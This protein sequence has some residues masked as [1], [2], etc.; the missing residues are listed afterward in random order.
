MSRHTFKDHDAERTR[1]LLR[2]GFDDNLAG[3]AIADAG[4]RIIACN[5]E[6]VRITGCDSAPAF[7]H[8]L[9]PQPGAFAGLL[10][11]LDEANHTSGTLMVQD[12][13][14]FVRRDDSP[15]QVIARI[16]ASV[17]DAGSIAETRVYLVDITDRFREEQELRVV[18]DRLQLADVAAQDVL[19]DWN[20]PAARVEW[21]SATARRFRYMSEE[22]RTGIDWHAE[23]VHPV[24]RERILRGLQRAMSGTDSTWTNEYRL[25]RGDGS[26]AAVLDRAHIV[27]N[28]RGEPVRVV[29]SIVDIT[30]LK[31]SEDAHRFLARAGAALEEVLDVNATAASLAHIGI[32]EYA[33]LCL[34]DLLQ[35]DGSLHRVAVAHAQPALEPALSL[36]ATVP[37]R[38]D[39]NSASMHAV[40][41]GE[42]ECE[43]G[44]EVGQNAIMKR[45]GLTP[46]ADARAYIVVPLEAR[47]RIMGAVTFGFSSPRRFFDPL[48]IQTVK[49]LAGCAAL[50][51]GNAHLYESAQRAIRSRNEVLGIV[52]HDLRSPLHTIVATLS[53]LDDSMPERRADIR[54][55]F[56]ILQRTTGQINHLIQDL[57]DVSRMES[58]HFTVDPRESSAAAIITEACETLRPLAAE[59]DIVISTDIRGDL[60]AVA[61]DPPEVVRVIG[62]LIGNAIKFSPAGAAIVVR[63]R[64]VHGEVRISVHDE[65]PG[66]PADQ[67]P[68]VFEHFW[69]GREKDRRGSGLGLAIARGIVEAHGGRIWVDSALDDG[70][71]FTFSLPV[72]GVSGNGRR[73]AASTPDV[74]RPDRPSADDPQADFPQAR[75]R[76]G[77]KAAPPYPDRGPRWPPRRRHGPTRG[78]G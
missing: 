73:A 67:I 13:I 58:M 15:M 24:D 78:V 44:M 25:L 23:R 61:A 43:S 63:A 18:A 50:A 70:S 16:S 5:R 21:G 45:L 65:G 36:N 74:D 77:R 10:A 54:R 64:A 11:R 51:L 14:R 17:N 56:D 68:L 42:L 6:F 1:A 75:D 12:E 55:L 49:Q 52:S 66:I 76:K 38:S 27:R 35:Q 26:Y 32:P 22:V 46:E 9:E 59:S 28:E 60:P 31:A 4:G 2:R 34:V 7:L 47:G 40:Q 8:E 19:W 29:G 37:S 71:T 41:T 57:L 30:E 48:Y 69:Q 62:N 3:Q 72:A 39:A 53:V 20:V 33:D